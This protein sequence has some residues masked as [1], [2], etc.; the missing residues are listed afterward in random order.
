MRVAYTFGELCQ[1]TL[2]VGAVP[3]CSGHEVPER[4]HKKPSPVRA[5]RGMHR[6][7]IASIGVVIAVLDDLR[8]NDR[9]ISRKLVSATEWSPTNGGRQESAQS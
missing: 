3:R 2:T 8:P 1:Q 9:V 6:V 5:Q 4:E 7:V